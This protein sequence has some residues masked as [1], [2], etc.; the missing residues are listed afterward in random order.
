MVFIAGATTT[1]RSTVCA[2]K[3][4][5]SGSANAGSRLPHVPSAIAASVL[6][7]SGATSS[8]RFRFASSMWST[9]SAP[10]AL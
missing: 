8:S 6:A 5:A 7:H 10:T 1:G 4:C 2:P 3:R 9:S